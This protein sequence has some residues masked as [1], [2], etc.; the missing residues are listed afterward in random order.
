MKILLTG[1]AGFIGYHLAEKLC[2]LGHKV[3][4]IDN[5]DNYYDVGLKYTRIKLLK[6]YKNFSFSQN[7]LNNLQELGDQKFDLAINFA[8]QAGVRL[9]NELAY[10]YTESNVKGFSYFLNF[11]KSSNIEKIIYAS[12]SSVYSGLNKYPFSEDLDLE[13]PMSIYAQTKIENEI[14]AEKY[15]V[16]NKSKIFGLRFFT[17]YGPY[18]RPDMAYYDFTKKIIS[19]KDIIVFNDGE[20]LRDMTYVDDIVQGISGLIENINGFNHGHEIFNLGNNKPEN[21]N[22]LISLIEE[23][24]KKNAQIKYIFNENEPTITHACIDKAKRYFNYEPKVSLNNGI[25]VFFNWFKVYYDL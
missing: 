7:N 23:E 4:G 13:K 24:F 6:K 16:Y 5:I 12:S 9:P 21:L 18:G 19:N 22:K 15:S 3:H 11:C 14:M 2:A 20:L 1:V 8:A 25:K 10:K 17:V